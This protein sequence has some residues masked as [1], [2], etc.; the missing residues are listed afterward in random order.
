MPEIASAAHDKDDNFGGLEVRDGGGTGGA[1]TG[2]GKGGMS[3]SGESTRLRVDA[4]SVGVGSSLDR[5]RAP[6]N[7]SRATRESPNGRRQKTVNKTANHL[8]RIE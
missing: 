7:A 6:T 3:S 8:R 4:S 1:S 2:G 5:L